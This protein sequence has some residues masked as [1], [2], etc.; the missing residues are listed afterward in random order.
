MTA[1]ENQ[2][3]ERELTP[4]ELEAIAGGYSF[5]EFWD[6]TKRVAGAI[7]GGVAA[8]GYA[9]GQAFKALGATIAGDKDTVRDIEENGLGRVGQLYRDVRDSTAGQIGGGL[10]IGA[11]AVVGGSY[12]VGALAG[13]A[14]TVAGAGVIVI[15][16]SALNSRTN[17]A[18]SIPI[19][20]TISFQQDFSG[21][22]LNDF[23]SS[24]QLKSLGFTTDRDFKIASYHDGGVCPDNLKEQI[25]A[26][27]YT[28]EVKVGFFQL[29]SQNSNGVVE[30][31]AIP[32][33]SANEAKKNEAK[34][35]DFTPP[36]STGG[37]RGYGRRLDGQRRNSTQG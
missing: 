12:V 35:D 16:I 37:F 20:R 1:M 36:Q 3:L 34:Q 4:E 8:G 22:K 23:F 31:I 32:V 11:A 15:A 29:V 19:D 26:A 7:P 10:I 25:A 2:E 21:K 17:S 18:P 28:G 24:D 33:I 9:V 6:D 14:G 27:G 5:G 13:S 30:S